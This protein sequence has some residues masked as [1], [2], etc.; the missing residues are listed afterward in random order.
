ML[1]E[2]IQT[3]G[4]WILL[5]P[6]GREWELQEA[7]EMKTIYIWLNLRWEGRFRKLYWKTVGIIYI[8]LIEVL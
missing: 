8:I 3:E 5:D 4:I 6:K 2:N 1:G 7:F